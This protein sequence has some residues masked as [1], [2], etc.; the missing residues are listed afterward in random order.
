[1]ALAVVRAHSIPLRSRGRPRGTIQGQA[2]RLTP[3]DW[4]LESHTFTLKLLC[5]AA[6]F[7]TKYIILEI[8]KRILL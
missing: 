3:D 8:G 4:N 2:S 7:A 6:E 5:R 1:M